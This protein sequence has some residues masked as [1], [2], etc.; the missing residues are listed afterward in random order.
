MPLGSGGQ[1]LGYGERTAGVG[2]AP[3]QEKPVEHIG[4]LGARRERY[5]LSEKLRELARCAGIDD[6]FEDVSR[7]FFRPL[8]VGEG[9]RLFAIFRRPYFGEFGDEAI[10]VVRESIRHATLCEWACPRASGLPVGAYPCAENEQHFFRADLRGEAPG[11]VH[12]FWEL[13]R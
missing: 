1:R 4:T 11:D 12:Q 13:A 10:A 6:L 9:E 7:A 5:E 8:A 3:G 2:L